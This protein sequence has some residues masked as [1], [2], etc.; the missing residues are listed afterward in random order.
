MIDIAGSLPVQEEK[1]QDIATQAVTGEI[2][3]EKFVLGCVKM[4]RDKH[5]AHVDAGKPEIDKSNEDVY[6]KYKGL[7]VRYS[8]FN[9][10]FKDHFGYES[11]A[12]TDRLIEEGQIAMKPARGGVMLYLPGDIQGSKKSQKFLVGLGLAK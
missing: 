5:Q 1:E 4:H 3:P 9:E 8:G 7:H 2:T 6:E 11:R 12:T 10:A